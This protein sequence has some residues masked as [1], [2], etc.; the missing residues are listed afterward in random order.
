MSDKVQ[1]YNIPVLKKN[2]PDEQYKFRMAPAPSGTYPFHLKLEDV[3]STENLDKKMVFHMLG[4]TGS[5]N[6]ADFLRQ[7]AGEMFRQYN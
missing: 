6:H 3:Q 5:I 7:V 2:Q 1:K 4:D